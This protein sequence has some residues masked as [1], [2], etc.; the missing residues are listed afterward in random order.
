MKKV[1]SFLST[2]CFIIAA[3]LGGI[4]LFVPDDKVTE[5]KE[6]GV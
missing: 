1:F 2:F 6:G 5:A 4:F 3:C